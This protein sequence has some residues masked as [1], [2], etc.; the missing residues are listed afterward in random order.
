MAAQKIGKCKACNQDVYLGENSGV[1]IG[2]KLRCK[3]VRT[4]NLDK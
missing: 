1:Y 3:N 2:H 4:K